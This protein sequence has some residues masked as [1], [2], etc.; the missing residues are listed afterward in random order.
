MKVQFNIFSE[1]IKKSIKYLI[2]FYL[3][4]SVYLLLFF[5]SSQTDLNSIILKYMSLTNIITLK[6]FPTLDI[7]ILLYQLFIYAFIM[8]NY[9]SYEKNHS[10]ENFALR[11]SS[12]KYFIVKLLG[13]LIINLIL[14][15]FY[16]AYLFCWFNQYNVISILSVINYFLYNMVVLLFM[17]SFVNMVI[18]NKIIMVI[19]FLV[20]LF[21]LLFFNI[22]I[23]LGDIVTLI[24]YSYCKFNIKN[25]L[26]CI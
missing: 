15:I 13:G 9:F 24:G 26:F 3:I 20:T 6:N 2:F 25:S 11:Y 21:L 17:F 5:S 14:T 1:I 16:F 18:K 8:A 7:L 12:K 4:L 22:Y 23:V 10:F 19:L